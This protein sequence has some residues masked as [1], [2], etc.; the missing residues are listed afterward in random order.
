MSIRSLRQNIPNDWAPV[1]A[2]QQE[3]TVKKDQ[4]ERQLNSLNK[5]LYKQ[6]LDK[7]L[8]EKK[9]A[10]QK[11][12]QYRQLENQYI[13]QKERAIKD[14]D[15]YSKQQQRLMQEHWA[16]EYETEM[17]QRTNQ[18]ANQFQNEL[19]KDRQWLEALKRQQAE[20][21]ESLRQM[22]EIKNKSEKQVLYEKQL[23]KEQENQRKQLEKLKDQEMIQKNIEEMQRRSRE[24]SQLI[25]QKD[26][27]IQKKTQAYQPV[28]QDSQKKNYLFYNLERKWEEDHKRKQEEDLQRQLRRRQ[29]NLFNTNYTIHNQLQ[30]RM[31][32]KQRE[33]EDFEKEK[34]QVR[35]YEQ[36]FREHQNQ[37]KQKQ[38][39]EKQ[40]YHSF[41]A[42]QKEE[43]DSEKMKQLKMNDRERR[44]HSEFIQTENKDFNFPGVPGAHPRESPLQS[45]FKRA[46]NSYRHIPSNPPSKASSNHGD[47]DSR[48]Y[49][50]DPR[51]HDPIVNP[52]GA[53][54]PRPMNS[55][56]T[57]GKGISLLYAGSTITRR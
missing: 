57:K 10:S 52:L 41:L 19:A 44:F 43:K 36:H 50:F 16:K 49:L 40:D 37:I 9:N 21:E 3:S 11:D 45:T 2:A 32:Q 7:Q 13:R 48:E 53:T 25:H 38:Q 28:A 5:K 4:E 26:R 54:V 42:Q 51:K 31:A 18:Q 56:L 12:Q 47:R 23:A 35:D 27:E 8:L 17:Q 34:K 30:E 1:I 46:Y 24:F 15:S 14:W 6:E 22:K 33:K 55:P 20:H 39:Q 29:E